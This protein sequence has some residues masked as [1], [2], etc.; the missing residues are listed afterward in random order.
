MAV[1]EGASEG[2]L[3]LMA[4]G[5]PLGAFLL[6]YVDMNSSRN[7]FVFGFSIYCGLAIPNW[8]NKNLETLHTGDSLCSPLLPLQG[9]N[10]WGWGSVL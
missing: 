4:L 6:Q 2:V 1:G 7:L 8:V 10:Q 3:V 5:L 9:L